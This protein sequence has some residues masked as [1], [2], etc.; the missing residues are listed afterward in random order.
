MCKTGLYHV[1]LSLHSDGGENWNGKD[2]REWRLPGLLYAD[3][4]A[5][6]GKLEEDYKAMVGVS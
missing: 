1:P 2:G 3:D 4:L 6:C 5:L